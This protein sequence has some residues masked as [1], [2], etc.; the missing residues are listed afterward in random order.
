MKDTFTS[1]FINKPKRIK[2]AQVQNSDH[3][4]VKGC[5]NLFRKLFRLGGDGLPPLALLPLSLLLLAFPPSLPQQQAK[6]GSPFNPRRSTQCILTTL[7]SVSTPS[8]LQQSEIHN[9][10]GGRT[11]SIWSLRRLDER[12]RTRNCGEWDTP[13]ARC[14]KVPFLVIQD[15][16]WPDIPSKHTLNVVIWRILPPDHRPF[17]HR[18]WAEIWIQSD[19]AI[20]HQ[21]PPPPFGQWP[22]GFWKTFNL[23]FNLSPSQFEL[24]VS[25]NYCTLLSFLPFSVP[26]AKSLFLVARPYVIIC[27]QPVPQ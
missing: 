13:A 24:L 17:H 15:P 8:L 6:A 5:L 1:Y 10:S 26:G 23:P 9:D 20:H 27:L 11:S 3:P 12:S 18:T 14:S 16:N 2:N 19:L 25:L 4:K 7:N 22:K 21:G